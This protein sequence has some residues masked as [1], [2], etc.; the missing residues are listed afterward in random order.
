MSS[1]PPP[2][3]RLR[4]LK[5]AGRAMTLRAPAGE[6]VDDDLTHVFEGGGKESAHFATAWR[7]MRFRFAFTGGWPFTRFDRT[8]YRSERITGW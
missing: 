8:S 6:G 5:L 4:T 2:V 3:Q 1:T 7:W